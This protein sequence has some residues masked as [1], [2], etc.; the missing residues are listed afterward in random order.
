MRLYQR[1][2]ER[3]KEMETSWTL[4][5]LGRESLSKNVLANIGPLIIYLELVV[6]SSFTFFYFPYHY[7]YVPS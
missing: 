1:K 4:G 7:I 6:R 2:K 3:K 5:I